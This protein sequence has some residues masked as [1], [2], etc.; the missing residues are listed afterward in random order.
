M[1]GLQP[2]LRSAGIV[3]ANFVPVKSTTR[4][5]RKAKAMETERPT[6]GGQ[7]AKP[8]LGQGMS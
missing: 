5:P 8:G 2:L 7:I 3:S 1:A 4:K 6:K